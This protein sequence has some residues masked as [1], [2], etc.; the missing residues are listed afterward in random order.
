VK[1]VFFETPGAF[2]AWL[3]RHHRQ[4]RILHVGFRKRHT[5]RPSLTWPEAVDEALCF[6]WI[7]GVRHRIDAEGYTI[8]FT[9]RRAGSTWSAVNLRRVRVLIRVGRMSPH[10]LRVYRQRNPSRTGLYSFEQLWAA[11]FTP[12]HARLFRAKRRAWQWFRAQAP[13]YRRTAT[14]WVES[15]K[16]E[17]TRRRRL[18][19]LIAASAAGR[20]VGPLDRKRGRDRG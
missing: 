19:A 11:R 5:G 9:P 18:A 4:Q 14:F 15:A 13:W 12:L 10:G 3:E 7:D 6:G 2:R 8:R 16:L 1:I 17:P 20:P